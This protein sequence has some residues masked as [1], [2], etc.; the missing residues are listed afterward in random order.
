MEHSKKPLWKKSI[1][2]FLNYSDIRDFLDEISNNGDMYGYENEDAA[3][4]YSEYKEQFDELA[5]GAYGLWEAMSQYEMRD[6]WDDMV[7]ALLG[8]QYTVLG[9][10]TLELDYFHMLDSW[11]ENLA[12]TEAEKRIELLTKRDMIRCFRSVMVTLTLF[13][14]IKAA[15][16]C[17]TSIVEELD[18]RAMPLRRLYEKMTGQDG[19]AFDK[20]IAQFPQRAWVE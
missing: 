5:A 20:I 12:V 16:D 6:I 9:Y 7:V 14:D 19:D 8:A 11:S 10:D 17:L 4:Y 15:H 18:D 2:Q 3:G 13:F 1:L